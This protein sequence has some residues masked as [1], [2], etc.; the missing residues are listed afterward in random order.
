MAYVTT[1]Q[2]KKDNTSFLAVEEAVT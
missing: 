1:N 2:Y